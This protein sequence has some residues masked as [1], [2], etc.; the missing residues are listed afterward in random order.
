VV[1][2]KQIKAITTKL[3]PNHPENPWKEPASRFRNLLIFSILY[4]TGMRRG[5]MSGLYVNDVQDGQVSIRRRQ[6][7]PLETRENAPNVKGGER[8]IPIPE[9]LARLI[10][11]YVLHHRGPQKHPYLFVS[12]KRNKGQ[13]LSYSGVNEV[14]KAARAGLPELEGLSPHHLRHHMNYRISQMIDANQELETATDKQIF[15]EDARPYLM[16]WSPDGTQQVRYNKRYNQETAGTMLVDRAE[17]L[18]K[19]KD[20]EPKET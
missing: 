4:E 18:N 19:G 3:L 7:N 5:E 6:N 14:F 11:H 17:R 2:E 10:D 9:E 1:S 20:D 16:G 8:T 13:P 15:D 12:H